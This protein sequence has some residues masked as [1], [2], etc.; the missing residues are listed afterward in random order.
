M[1]EK[2]TENHSEAV[3]AAP[4]LSRA[5]RIVHSIQ[6]IP[7]P[8]L[9]AIVSIILIVIIALFVYMIWIRPSNMS[10]L[11]ERFC[12]CTEEVSSQKVSYSKDGF[13]YRTDLGSCFLEE[14]QSYSEGYNKMEKKKLLEEFQQEVLQ[15]CPNKLSEVFEYK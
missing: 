11:A 8:V 7:R 15:Q 2:T 12:T 5:D 13:G 10:Y 9:I 14:F 3:E 4:A 6:E 1:S